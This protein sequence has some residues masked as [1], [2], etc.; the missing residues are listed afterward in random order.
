MGVCLAAL[1]AGCGGYDNADYFPLAAGAERTM[2]VRTQAAVGAETTSTEAV[3]VEERVRGLEEVPGLG[4]LWV[5]E[6]ALDSGPPAV[7]FF[8]RTED[9]VTQVVPGDTGEP[10]ELTL[11][12]LPLTVGLKWFDTERRDL[13]M[14]VVALDTLVLGNDTFPDCF[15]VV[16]RGPGSDSARLWLAP[17]IG[18]VKWERYRSF[19]REDGRQVGIVQRAELVEY[20]PGQVEWPRQ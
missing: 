17:N 6:Y 3:R 15:E 8:R 4:R 11:L 10:S 13:V 5:V 7:S 14:E 19:R 9:A 18:A 2:K 20:R 12:S 1:L 16:T